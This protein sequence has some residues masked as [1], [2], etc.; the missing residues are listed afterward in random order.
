MALTLS[1][2]FSNDSKNS[3]Y[4]GFSSE[5]SKNTNYLTAISNW[6]PLFFTGVSFVL[7]FATLI[8]YLIIDFSADGFAFLYNVHSTGSL[9]TDFALGADGLSVVFLV[10]T[11]FVFPSCFVLSRSL[12]DNSKSSLLVLFLSFV[13]L[14]EVILLFIFLLLDLF[15]F[16]ICFEAILIPMFMLIGTWGSRSRR[17]K[18]AYYFF[19]YTLVTSMLLF[20]SLF[21]IN[22]TVGSTLYPILIDQPFDYVEQLFLATAFFITFATKAPMIPFHIWLPEAH[23]EA[24]TVGSVILAAL[25]LKL[26]GYGFLRFSLPIFVEAQRA[27]VC[28]VYVLSVVGILY[29]SLTTIRQIDMKRIIAY[30]S[31]AHMNLAVLGLYSFTQQGID[32]A[33]YLMLGHGVV[34]GALFICVGV[35]Y[36]RHHTRLLRYY[37]GLVTV[38]PIFACLFFVFTLANMGFPGTVNF[39]GEFLI[40]AGVFDRNAFIATMAAPAIVLSAVYSIWLYNRLIFGTLK[41][42]HY[43]QSFSDTNRLERH[44]LTIYALAAL[45]FG[46]STTD[47]LDVIYPATKTLVELNAATGQL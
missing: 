23:V 5:N 16:Y 15:F 34:S 44:I 12:Q 42:Q 36:D 20:A 1:T 17:I 32:G 19:L 7:A 22:S 4:S 11:G 6:A 30:S 2:K 27:L 10:L 35:L 18:A 14:M 13:L 46:L 24:P 43:L 28:F 33:I 41:T 40:Y 45:Y 38:M 26:G 29:A 3:I 21:F 39:V 37:S 31:V 25:L 9:Q 47:I 8:V